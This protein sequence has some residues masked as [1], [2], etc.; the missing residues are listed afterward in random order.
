MQ[1]LH[2]ILSLISLFYFFF[3]LLSI[4]KMHQSDSPCCLVGIFLSL[5][6]LTPHAHKN[7][8]FILFYH[9]RQQYFSLKHFLQLT[10]TSP[11]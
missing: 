10:I 7:N 5:G 8:K 3:P 1:V 2:E 9:L 11:K 6:L 4:F